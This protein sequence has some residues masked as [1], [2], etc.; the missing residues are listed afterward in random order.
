MG[1][2]CA[3][4]GVIGWGSQAPAQAQNLRDSFA[5]AGMDTKVGG[6]FIVL[7][8]PERG[9]RSNTKEERNKLFWLG[10]HVGRLHCIAAVAA[11]TAVA[12][13]RAAGAA[14]RDKPG[15]GGWGGRSMA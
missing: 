6:L 3:Q 12:L 11:S 1:L 13:F 9:G 5:A 14:G 4:V 15:G 2:V 7:F 10:D 8:F